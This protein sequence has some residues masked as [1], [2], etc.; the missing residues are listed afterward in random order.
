MCVFCFYFQQMLTLA[1]KPIL[2][3]KKKN[4]N[5]F[6]IWGEG[7]SRYVHTCIRAL[8]VSLASRTHTFGKKFI[9]SQV[10]ID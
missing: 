9:R 2:T 10:R 8:S 5:E 6:R 3:V 1:S 4:Q 7:V